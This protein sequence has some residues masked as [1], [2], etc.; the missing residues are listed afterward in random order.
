MG[1]GST[2]AAAGGGA[3]WSSERLFYYRQQADAFR[4]YVWGIFPRE[5]LWRRSLFTR[6]TKRS[7]HDRNVIR[8]VISSFAYEKTVG[9]AARRHRTS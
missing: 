9:V 5:I 7:A 2:G 1:K 3:I 4:E 8:T 6:V